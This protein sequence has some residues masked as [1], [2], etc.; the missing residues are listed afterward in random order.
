MASS[1]GQSDGNLKGAALQ[2]LVGVH[3]ASP[4]ESHRWGLQA[5]KS[6]AERKSI[7]LCLIELADGIC[8]VKRLEHGIACHQH[9]G[10]CFFEVRSI[11]KAHATVN[12][13]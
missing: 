8:R 9:I 11:V 7:P 3:Q 4:V 13:D 5:I 10:P 1:K 6:A 12:F 2:R